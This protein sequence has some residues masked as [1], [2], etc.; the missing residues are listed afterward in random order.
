MVTFSRS[1]LIGV[2]FIGDETARIHGTQED[3]IYA[4]EIEMDVQ[5]ASGEILAIQGL[6]RRYTTPVCPRAVDVLQTAVGM[7]LRE[8]GWT[9]KIMRE[10][11]RKGCEH[12]AEIINECG[13]SLDQA[14]MTRDLAATLEAEPGADLAQAALSWLEEHPEAQGVP[15]A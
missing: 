1:Q 5:I 10:I 4:M 12:F 8:E 14:R 3:H 2:E 9:S 7:S 6:M 15:L 13:R 11:G